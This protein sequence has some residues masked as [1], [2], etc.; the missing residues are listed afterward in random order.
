MTLPDTEPVRW[1]LLRFAVGGTYDLESQSPGDVLGTLII[2][3]VPTR[4]RIRSD[5]QQTVDGRGIDVASTD[6]SVTTDPP[7][8]VCM[9]GRAP[10]VR[11]TSV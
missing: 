4:L 7:P 6:V 8:A 3:P 2:Q 1:E 5:L 10:R 11:L 9:R